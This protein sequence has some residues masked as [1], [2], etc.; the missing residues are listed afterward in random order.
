[1]STNGDQARAEGAASRRP[2][3]VDLLTEGADTQHTV[4]LTW[5]EA[6]GLLNQLLLLDRLE[7]VETLAESFD[8][9]GQRRVPYATHQ[10][11]AASIRAAL[12]PSPSPQ[13]PDGH[14]HTRE[15]EDQG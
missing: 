8:R 2:G 7:R 5:Q 9:M 1:M 14:D 4:A 10:A 15:S 12:L 13:Q 11:V 3:V 6:R